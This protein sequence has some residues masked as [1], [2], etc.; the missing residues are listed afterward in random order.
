MK[1]PVPP[2]VNKFPAAKQRRLD[3]LLEKN[4][5]GTITPSE[6]ATLERLV[7]EAEELMVANAKR[8]VES[9][10]RGEAN[11]PIGAF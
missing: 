1:K 6:R 9:S 2:R 10:K 11:P 3:Q 5:E 7:V 4:S 8:L